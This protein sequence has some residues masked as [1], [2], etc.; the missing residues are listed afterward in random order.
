MTLLTRLVDHR[1]AVALRRLATRVSADD[2]DC[3]PEPFSFGS[4]VV[5][6]RL[7]AGRL[8]FGGESK[9]AAPGVSPFG[10]GSAMWERE[11]QTFGWLDDFATLAS[12][13]AQATARAWTADW[14]KKS[15]TG[16]GAGWSL[17][18]TAE[19]LPRQ[20]GHFGFLRQYENE[21]FNAAVVRSM[22]LGTV[23]LGERWA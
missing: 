17:A 11:A 1:H 6:T 12:D 2:A 21:N 18:V 8:R 4:S 16:G 3:A 14:L 19:R 20:I 9:E 10:L 7:V 15:G 23:Y 22:R 5:A 13:E